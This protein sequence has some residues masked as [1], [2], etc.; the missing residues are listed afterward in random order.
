VGGNGIFGHDTDL[1]E[2]HDARLDI[3]CGNGGLKLNL[4]R[5]FSFEPLSDFSCSWRIS[6][7]YVVD[8]FVR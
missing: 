8:G 1:G 3:G 2:T 7:V 5:P 4:W 6:R